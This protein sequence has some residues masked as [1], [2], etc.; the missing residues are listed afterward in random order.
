MEFEISA[1]NLHYVKDNMP[2]AASLEIKNTK[3]LCL[4]LLQISSDLG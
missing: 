4:I 2:E 1:F 3:D